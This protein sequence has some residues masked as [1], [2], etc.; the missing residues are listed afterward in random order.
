MK[1][2]LSS[3]ESIGKTSGSRLNTRFGPFERDDGWKREIIFNHSFHS[4]H[5]TLDFR[6]R[7]RQTDG[8]TDT[9][10]GWVKEHDDDDDGSIDR[11][12]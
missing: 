7:R 11:S 4:L 2:T 5:P 10:R 9:R 12:V 6:R 8:R 1:I 3:S